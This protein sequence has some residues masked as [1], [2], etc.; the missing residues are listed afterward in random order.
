MHFWFIHI[1]LFY[2]RLTR[3]DYTNR[4]TPI[5]PQDSILARLL[6]SFPD[7]VFKY[8][9]H[10][11]LL[12]NKMEQELSEQEKNEAWAAYERDLQVNSEIR[13]FPNPE[14]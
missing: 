8:H 9:E 12:E 6:R 10:D 2:D 7:L 5:L 3:P 4:P 14:E 1:H 13:E 11:S